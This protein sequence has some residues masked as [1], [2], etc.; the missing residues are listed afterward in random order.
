M[1]HLKLIAIDMDGVALPDTFSPVI[2]NL[3]KKWGGEYTAVVERNVFSQRRNDAASFLKTHFNREESIPQILDIYFNERDLYLESNPISPIKELKEFLERLQSLKLKIIAYGGLEKDHFNKELKE[4]NHF[5]DGEKYIC[6]NDFRPGIK[7]IIV[8]HYK[9][10][11]SNVLFIDDV[12]KVAEEAK[13]LNVPFIG[14]PSNFSNGYQKKEMER[15][16]VKYLIENLQEVNEPML[17]KIDN[18][19]ENK[20]IWG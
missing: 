16:G 14:L 1:K 18:D 2:F 12:N 4:Y 10:G 20:R 11:F 17:R 15:T 19:V 8:D 7:E 5:F 9:H 3:V 13:K 6:T